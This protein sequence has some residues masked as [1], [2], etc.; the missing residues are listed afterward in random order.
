MTHD[1]SGPP[2]SDGELA[3]P[4]RIEKLMWNPQLDTETI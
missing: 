3:N 1:G 4:G 2:V